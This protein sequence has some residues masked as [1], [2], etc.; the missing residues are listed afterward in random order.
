V[1]DTPASLRDAR[2][3]AAGDED[4]AG[5]PALS[6]VICTHN[7][8]TFLRRA[9]ASALAQDLPSEAFEIIVVDN[10]STD[11]T[12]EVV[13]ATADRRVRYLY[14]QQ[15]GLCHARNVGWRSARA[16]C[17]A[18]LDDDAVAAPGWARKIVEAFNAHAEVAV[19]GGRTIPDWE[20]PQP[21]WLSDH[22]ALVLAITDWSPTPRILPDIA[23]EWLVGANMAVRVSALAEVGGF[24]P[25]LDRIGHNMLSGGDVFL[26]KQL[27][28]R[29]YHCLYHPD[30][31]VTHTVPAARLTRSWFLRR[32][33]WQ[34]ISDAMVVMITRSP[35]PVRRVLLALQRMIRLLGRPRRALALIV[36]A[37]GQRWFTEKCFAWIEVG[38][39]AGL[40]GA[41]RR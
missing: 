26:Q 40:L 31:T 5:T 38:H 3:I 10:G 19:V 22:A 35:G 17:V 34:G 23:M 24:H 7:R 37:R 36:P 18:Y 21:A 1:S 15:L 27:V 29:G 16:A 33:Y 25:R 13:R 9:L 14:E 41:V 12:A 6:V 4:A 28:E 32:Y 20:N 8:A 11:D 39:I 2:P 30:V